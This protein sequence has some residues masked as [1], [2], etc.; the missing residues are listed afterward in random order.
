MRAWRAV[1]QWR[2][3]WLSREGVMALITF[4][5][6]VV[7]AT[8]WVALGT[9]RG[10]F[11]VTGVLI[12]I[13]ALVTVYCTAMI[14]RSLAPIRQWS[15]PTTVPVYLALALMTGAAWLHAF[16]LTFAVGTTLT[17][18]VTGAIAVLTIPIGYSLK[19]TAW[20]RDYDKGAP[21]LQ[22]ATGLT[23]TT[24]RS[25]EWPH[26]EANFLLKEMGFR[27]AR[28][29]AKRLRGIATTAGFILPLLLIVPTVG[30]GGLLALV[31]AALAALSMTS[32]VAI[33]RWLFFAEAKHTVALY[34][35]HHD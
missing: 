32:G 33:E 28:K 3:S 23:G 14:Y 27:I 17:R 5:P 7:F 8:G 4:I 24:V 11:A 31:P 19:R 13:C 26:T 35:G 1:S 30:R 29:H 10:L 20:L 2:T 21:T 12:A 25:V 6:T 9:T 15:N 34:Y 18:F 22:T 16:T